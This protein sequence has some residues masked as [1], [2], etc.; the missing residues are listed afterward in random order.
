MMQYKGYIGVVEV[1]DEAGMLFGRVIGLRDVITFQGT[2]VPETRQ[3]FRDSVDD[4][5]EM[6]RERGED[7]ERPFSGK[8]LLR[9]APELHRALVQVAE[10]GGVS[11]NALV[12][13]ILESAVRRPDLLPLAA[14]SQ[15]QGTG[16]R[17]RT[18]RAVTEEA[19]PTAPKEGGEGPKAGKAGRG[20]RV[21][22][23]K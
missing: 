16:K 1:D 8:F 11:L 5:L 4:Y 22:A 3:A 15:P 20:G 9:I 7:P 10:A 17:R 19:V 6:C 13:R 21:R 14:R 18:A 2:T 23:R 12:E